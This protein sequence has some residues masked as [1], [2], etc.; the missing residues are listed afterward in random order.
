MPKQIPI[1]TA[2]LLLASCAAIAPAAAQTELVFRFNDAQVP[3][4]RAALDRFEAE[5]PDIEVEL[6]TIAWRDARDQ[7]LR[8]AAVGQ[9]PDVVHIAFVW[10]REMAEAG[11]TL[12]LDPL[13]EADPLPAGIKDFIGTA[14]AKGS[15]GQHY[16]LPWTTDT[17]AM[18]Y[19]TDVLEEAG[20][21]PPTTWDEL[22][23]ASRQ[24]AANT[25]KAGWGYPAGSSASCTLWFM[26]NFYWWSNGHTLIEQADDGGFRMGLGEAEVADAIR[27]FKRF[28]DDGE[29]PTAMLAAS[30]AHDPSILQSLLQ[31]D[32]G[33]AIL[34][35]NPYREMLANWREANPDAE[36]PFASGPMMAGSE[37]PST[38]RGGRHLAIN[39]ST[40]HPEEAWRLVKFLAS[41][42]VFEDH[43]VTQSPAQTTLLQRIDFPPEMDGYVEQLGNTRDWGPYSE[44][45]APIGSLWNATCRSFGAAV[46][47]QRTPEEA[48]AEFVADVEALIRTGGQ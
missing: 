14:L 26:A 21:A 44:G 24:V 47:G 32:Q 30:D 18:V 3:E 46:A 40:D 17:W 7:F 8:E 43:Y 6:Q 48:A 39:A 41:E 35:P 31:G 4:M 1:R 33:I 28:V 13:I 45:P 16:A 19:R 9:G 10:G 20:V 11:A 23:E 42:P 5:N 15:D 2:A 36:P 22:T 27:Y 25:D 37:A 38:H 34:P 12:P 29:T